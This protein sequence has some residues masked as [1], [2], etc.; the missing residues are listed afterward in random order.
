MANMRI[1]RT[2]TEREGPRP[3]RSKPRWI[4]VL[5]LRRLMSARSFV[6]WLRQL[7]SWLNT[8]GPL[9]LRNLSTGK[10]T[11]A[12]VED[13]TY[14]CRWGAGVVFLAALLLASLLPRGDMLAEKFIQGMIL[15][16][17][18]LIGVSF[19]A[20]RGFSIEDEPRQ[21]GTS[22][23]SYKVRY[24]RLSRAL[25]DLYH[26][27]A[28]FTAALL[29]AAVYGFIQHKWSGQTVANFLT[30]ML[31]LFIAASYSRRLI[32]AQVAEL[33]YIKGTTLCREIAVYWLIATALSVQAVMEGSETAISQELVSGITYLALVRISSEGYK[34]FREALSSQSTARESTSNGG[35]G[36]PRNSSP[37][38]DPA[39]TA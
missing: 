30:M 2:R 34:Q 4:R 18:V 8:K 22:T 25:H 33:D 17:L 13:F 3:R 9:W 31:P 24:G 19:A 23:K 1:V 21:G 27:L 14:W 6:R 26:A 37:K 35:D 20:K 39:T 38:H 10:Y 16:V 5:T 7:H 11:Q 36:Q 29:V 28:F 15:L 12:A 32:K